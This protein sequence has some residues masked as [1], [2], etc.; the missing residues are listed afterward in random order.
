MD[1]VS[2]QAARDA[3]SAPVTPALQPIF[4]L[5]TMS[6]VGFEALA[7]WRRDDALRPDEVFSAARELGCSPE[8]DAKCFRAALRLAIDVE[9]AA[10]L[11]LFV[12][13]EPSTSPLSF[14][15]ADLD[16]MYE[17][18]SRGVQIVVEVTE[19][20]LLDD[21]SAVLE[22]VTHARDAGCLVALDDV[23]VTPD[24]VMLLPLVRPDIVKLDRS[25]LRQPQ[26]KLWFATVTAILDSTSER[27]GT[28]L[29]EGIESAADIRVA[30][31]AGATLGQGFFLGEPTPA[32][33]AA[34][35]RWTTSRALERARV[36]EVVVNTPSDAFA[37]CVTSI[38]EYSRV[39][40]L[41]YEIGHPERFLARGRLFIG[42]QN[43]D[44]FVELFVE[45]YPEY[46]SKHDL[47]GVVGLQE[48][49]VP[50][51]RDWKTGRGFDGELCFA[52]LTTHDAVAFVAQD[53]GD[54]G[55]RVHR[56]YRWCMVSDRALVEAVAICIAR[57]L[58]S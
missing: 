17:V 14:T 26:S 50:A 22:T 16:L 6:V 29:F 58:D 25:L 3:L 21:V 39:I 31:A 44:L 56:R 11:A 5:D 13:I 54:A 45:C 23:G 15:S 27:D 51:S 41:L 35:H 19:R 38:A 52:L 30:A 34:G 55:P 48:V 28:V 18:R 33:A 7:R 10:P 24:S 1:E 2:K 8:L 53:M 47:V 43:P 46:S 9:F 36:D 37:R 42:V 4:D 32:E 40:E 20:G 57:R 49:D 12:N